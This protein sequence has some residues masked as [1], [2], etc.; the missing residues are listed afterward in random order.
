[1]STSVARILSKKG[2][3][4]VTTEPGATVY[5]AIQ[6][7]V[8]KNVGAI[9]VLVGDEVRGIFTE[10]DYLRRITLEGRTSKTTRV[11]EVMTTDVL[12]ITPEVTIEE[13]LALM[14]DKKIRHL[15]V[16]RD[17]QLAGIVSIG[18]CVKELS[19]IERVNVEQLTSYI[20]GVYPN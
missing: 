9:V 17:G 16:L 5:E 18:D 20:R 7:M 19:E 1:M 12:Y 13:C 14:T 3:G 4:V 8:D 6:K 2:T 10:R 15:P 11:E